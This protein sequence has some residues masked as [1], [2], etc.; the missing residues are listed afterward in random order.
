MQLEFTDFPAFCQ[1]KWIA[2]NCT[3]KPCFGRTLRPLLRPKRAHF[4]K[5]PCPQAGDWQFP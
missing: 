2:L 3:E 4:F 5:R 1:A